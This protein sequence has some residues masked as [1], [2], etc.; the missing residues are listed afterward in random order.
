M[1][2]SKLE[3]TS[4]WPGY[5]D[6]L[7][8]V[9]LNI[10]FLVG[11]M[12]VGLVTLNVEALAN[13]KSAKQA[14][15]LQKIN[16]EN[17]LLAALGTLLEAIPLPPKP[18]LAVEKNVPIKPAPS[19]Q[20]KTVEPAPVPAPVAQALSVFR[21]GTPFVLVSASQEQA[22]LQTKAG[23]TQNVGAQLNTFD[24]YAL[25]YQLSS[26]QTTALRQQQAN[27][28]ADSRWAVLVTVPEGQER[29]TREAFWRMTSV[30]QVLISQ[31]VSADAISMRTIMQ[32]RTNFS[33]GRR[34]FVYPQTRA[35]AA[36]N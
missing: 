7:V 30:R 2:R 32:E 23:F 19:Q 10:L 11:L 3:D 33:N 36:V 22:F 16:E 14:Q 12:A 18:V 17:M 29:A 24:F 9:V 26:A 28:P 25:Q 6:A 5:V 35:T 31:G 1:K 34:V 20:T 21:V 15:Q 13:F 4:Y 8:N 27:A